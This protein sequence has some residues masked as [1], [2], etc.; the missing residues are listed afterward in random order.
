MSSSDSKASVA[1]KRWRLKITTTLLGLSLLCVAEV[2]AISVGKT[3]ADNSVEAQM[4]AF[5]VHPDFEINLFADESMGIAN[6]VAMHWDEQGRLWV[7]TTLT[8]AQLEPGESPNDT[9]VILEDTDRDGRADIS[10]VFADGLEMPMGF[11]LGQGGVYLG[12]GP[13]LLFLKDT[14]GDN[15][16]DTREVLLTGFGT[17]DTHQNISNFTWGPDGCLYFAQGLHCYSRVETP[18]G[19]VRGD[20]AGFWRFH[21]E[22]L[23]LEPFCFPSLAS[24]NPCGIAFDKTGAMFLKSNNRELIYVTPGLVPTSHPNNLVPVGSI[25]ITPGKSMGAEY[26]ESAHLPGWTQNSMLVSGYYAHRVTSFPLVTEGAGYAVVEPVEILVSTHSSFR[27]VETRIGPDGA[28]YVADWFNPIIGHY[29]ASLRHPDRDETH[30]RVWRLTT[31]GRDLIEMDVTEREYELIEPDMSSENPRARLEAILAAAARGNAEAMPE[32]LKALDH[33]LDRF[34]EY[35]LEQTVQ[36]L[37]P[38]WISALEAGTAEPIKPDHLAYLLEKIGG[39]SAA[40]IAR[41]ELSEGDLPSALRARF[42]TILARNGEA[43]DVAMLITGFGEN[44]E[45]LSGISSAAKRPGADVSSQVGQLLESADPAVR[46]EA[47][48]M[49]GRWKLGRLKSEV[50]AL[51][52][53]ESVPATMRIAAIQARVSLEGAACVSALLEGFDSESLAVQA[54]MIDSLLALAPG[55]V[56]ATAGKALVEITSAEDA[57]LL[58][59]PFFRRKAATDALR[60]VLSKIEWTPEQAGILVSAMSQSGLNDEALLGILQDAMGITSGDRAYSVDFVSELVRE[61]Q[62]DGDALAG[63][64]VYSRAQLTC[65]ACHQLEGVGGMIGPSL[66]AVGAGL[67]PDLLIESVLWPSRQLKEGYF[68]ITVF[69]KSGDQF[70]GYRDKEVNGI[71]NLRDTATGVVREIPR[72]EIS[73]IQDIGSLMP[74]G[75]TNGLSREELRDMIAYL[76]TLKG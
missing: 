46:A 69:T 39:T 19:V 8:Y 35:A 22:A 71:F 28:I 11:A 54:A 67:S 13:D 50:A 76:A 1:G 42:A 75:L 56:A 4:K 17:G 34:I 12:E 55:K 57:K 29:Q 59:A 18:W 21:P 30:G 31:K 20:A 49:I 48:K 40:A 68:A 32:A 24:Q 62:A 73:R 16:A 6:P 66:D 47:V 15:R 70:S 52:E 60:E 7:L 74:K 63:R 72:V 51:S 61:V 9:L 37:C 25:G 33:P 5:E 38:V 27:P 23:K 53:D 45:V 43:A 10:T 2:F 36:S 3:A 65:A 64:E 14:D 44:A 41:R 58:L 26:V